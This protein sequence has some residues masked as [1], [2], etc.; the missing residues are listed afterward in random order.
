[1]DLL[2]DVAEIPVLI[3]DCLV[4]VF[5]VGVQPYLGDYENVLFKFAIKLLSNGARTT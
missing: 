5:F 3:A 4:I 2:A 1:M